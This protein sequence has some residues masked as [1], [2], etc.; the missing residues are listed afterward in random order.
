MPKDRVA[1]LAAEHDLQVHRQ[2]DIIIVQ[3]H[4]GNGLEDIVAGAIRIA[5]TGAPVML[6]VNETQ[7]PV[8]AGES[9]LALT[10]RYYGCTF[11]KNLSPSRQ[12]EQGAAEGS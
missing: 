11:P 7:V 6:R 8:I 3:P 4:P 5:D 10:T 1:S 9:P 12:L 2:G